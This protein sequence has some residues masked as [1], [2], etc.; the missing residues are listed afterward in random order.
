MPREV[1]NR[2]IESL[3]QCEITYG[4]TLQVG[5]RS[6]MNLAATSAFDLPISA[7]LQLRSNAIRFE[8]QIKQLTTLR[9]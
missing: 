7:F 2:S 5:I 6:L 1:A 9:K 3:S 4:V 8:C